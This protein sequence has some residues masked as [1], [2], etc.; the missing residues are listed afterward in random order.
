MYV[1][2]RDGTREDVRFDAITRRLRPLC[3]GDLVK[4][5]LELNRRG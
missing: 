5:L 3:E 1:V 4:I 2:K